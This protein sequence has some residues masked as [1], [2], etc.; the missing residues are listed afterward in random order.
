MLRPPPNR[1][2][3]T[4]QLLLRVHRMPRSLAA[5]GL[6]RYCLGCTAEERS[7]R[8]LALCR[9]LYTRILCSCVASEL[10]MVHDPKDMH[11]NEPQNANV[12]SRVQSK[13]E[14]SHPAGTAVIIL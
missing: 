4:S 12:L 11:R 14:L 9:E 13:L 6:P 8:S 5:A 7:Q 1:Q 2:Q 3:E 10:G